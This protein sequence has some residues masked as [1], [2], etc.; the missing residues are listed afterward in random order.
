[1][2]VLSFIISFVCSFLYDSISALLYNSGDVMNEKKGSLFPSF[3]FLRTKC[4]RQ[5]FVTGLMDVKCWPG[6]VI[7][8]CECVYWKTVQCVSVSATLLGNVTSWL[9]F[10]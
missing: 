9:P 5:T 8:S 1:M 7:L 10:E 3:L 2:F 4:I 6:D